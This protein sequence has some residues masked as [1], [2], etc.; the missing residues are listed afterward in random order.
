MKAKIT[1]S[2]GTVVELEGLTDDVVKA[3]QALAPAWAAPVYVPTPWWIEPYRSPFPTITWT[4]TTVT[5]EP[6]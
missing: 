2:D 3:I 4:S 6:A 1:K 5:P